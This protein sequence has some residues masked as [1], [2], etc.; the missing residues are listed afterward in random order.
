MHS[1]DSWAPQ[2]VP[3]K[4]S[5]II[6]KVQALLDPTWLQSCVVPYLMLN[7]SSNTTECRT[8]QKVCCTVLSMQYCTLGYT[9]SR[10]PHS[11][12]VIPSLNQV[13]DA[14]ALVVQELSVWSRSGDSYAL[15]NSPGA[16]EVMNNQTQAPTVSL[17]LAMRPT[18][19]FLKVCFTLVID[20][21]KL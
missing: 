1:T 9:D 16:G 8:T 5:N 6:Y 19:T 12:A 18:C 10:G 20:T 2:A 7:A 11:R 4:H 17:P 13:H 3:P 15:G 14:H 21:I